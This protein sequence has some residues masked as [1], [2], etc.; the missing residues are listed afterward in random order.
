MERLSGSESGVR[1]L[2]HRRGCV[3]PRRKLIQFKQGMAATEC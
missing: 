3:A 1:V 2:L